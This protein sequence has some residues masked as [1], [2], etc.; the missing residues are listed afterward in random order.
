MEGTSFHNTYA[1]MGN[2]NKTR[3]AYTAIVRPILEYGAVCWDHM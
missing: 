3:L 2:N 1:Q